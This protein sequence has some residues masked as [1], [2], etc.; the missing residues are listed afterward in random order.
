MATAPGPR[1]DNIQG[2]IFG[3]FSKDFQSLSFLQFTD[4]DAGRAW[5][6]TMAKELATSAEVIAF[7]DLFK[8]LTARRGGELGLL[9]VTWANLAFTHSGL[10]ALGVSPADLA[11]FPQ[12]FRDGMKHRATQ[13]GDVGDSDPKHWVGRLGS[14]HVH[15]VLIVASDAQ[16]D[17]HQQVS[18]YMQNIMA[19]GTINLIFA[20]EGAVRS[21]QPGHEH[22]GF[23]DGVSQ[24]GVRGIDAPDDPVNNPDQGHPGQDLLHPGEFVLG[25]PTQIPHLD[26]AKPDASPNPTPGPISQSGPAWTVDGSYLVF[27]RLRQRVPAFHEYV[28]SQAKH[29]GL[30][31]DQ[32]GAK[33]VGRWAT[34]APLEKRKDEP[35]GPFVLPPV[36]PGITD[37]TLPGD[38]SRNNNFEYGGDTEPL[39]DPEGFA[40]PRA[41]HIRKA[42]PRDETTILPPNSGDSESETQ[43]HRL[44]RRGI[45]FGTS[46]RPS[47]GATSHGSDAVFPRD[48]GLLF[49]CYQTD[50]ERQFEFVQNAWVNNVDFP[51]AGDGQ[52]PIIAQRD[53]HRTFTLPKGPGTQ[54]AHLKL[55]THFVVTTGGDYFFQPS[56]DAIVKLGTP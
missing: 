3:G 29:Q 25:Y 35:A 50:L 53:A 11:G 2:N 43:T 45:P 41:A 22:F 18:R 4:R 15:A 49:L 46:F 40:V 51:K 27:R 42:Y 20:Q 38:D 21:D 28:A 56:I 16:S 48:R 7:N 9:K 33:L 1:V 44:L 31:D 37:P 6:A 55:M 5:V 23:K 24:P 47:L 32:M 34:G 8:R 13:I 36:D 19:N 17:L 14:K 12:A 52:D 10:E 26:P 30:T 39:K 54:P